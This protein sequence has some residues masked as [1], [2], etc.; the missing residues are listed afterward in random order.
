MSQQVIPPTAPW[1]ATPPPAG[2]PM[3]PLPQGPPAGAPQTPLSSLQ[4]QLQQQ[5]SQMQ[6]QIKQSEQ[7]LNA[8]YQSLI[9]QQQVS[10][11]LYKKLFAGINFGHFS[12]YIM[13]LKL[14]N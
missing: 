9:Q 12:Y 11:D 4:Q 10:F 3:A 8:Q 6:E 7:N 13:K 5:L 2:G 14:I 1:Q